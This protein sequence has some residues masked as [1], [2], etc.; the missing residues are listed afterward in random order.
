MMTNIKLTPH[1]LHKLLLVVPLFILS[2]LQVFAQTAPSC[3]NTLLT[4]NQTF[5]VPNGSVY[6]VPP[7]STFNGS[8]LVRAGGHVIVCVNG[9][10]TGSVT[11]DPGGT[12]WD[13]PS[14]SYTGSLFV[15]GNRYNSAS[16]CAQFNPCT[17]PSA[18]TVTTPNPICAGTQTGIDGS[19][20]A[21]ATYSWEKEN[22][23]NANNWVAIGGNTEDLAAATIG[24]LTTTTRFRRRTSACSPAQSSAWVTVTISVNAL[25]TIDLDANNSSLKSGNDYQFTFIE[26][27]GLNNNIGDAS[28]LTIADDNA[29]LA[30]ATIVLTNKQ[31]GDY[32]TW[33]TLGGIS[34]TADSSVANRITLN[35]S[36]SSSVANYQTFIRGIIFNNGSNTPNTTLRNV[37]FVV[38]DGSCSSTTATTSITVVAV[39][40]KPV[41]DL[42]KT[43]ATAPGT[44]S[45]KTYN[46]KTTGV[47]ITNTSSIT[48]AD[49]T[50]LK[51]A[52]I[53]LTNKFIGDSILVKGALP[54]G[55]TATF[56]AVSSGAITIN[57]TSTTTNTLAE[58]QTALDLIQFY[59][60]SNNPITTDRIINFTVND[61][62]DN[63]NIAVATIKVVSVNDKTVLDLD[64]LSD[65]VATG[66]DYKTTYEE[67]KS[68]VTIGNN[69]SNGVS[70]TDADNTTLTGA[71]IVLTNTKTADVFVVSN[72]TALTALGITAISTTAGSNT[73]IKFSGNVSLANYQSAIK[74]VTFSNTA[75][76][77]DLTTRL[78]KV[79][80][81]DGT[82][83][84][85]TA[86][87][88]IVFR[89]FNDC[90][91]LSNA[92]NY[93]TTFT[94][95]GAKVAVVNSTF[96]ITDLDL[97][98]AATTQAWTATVQLTNG[99]SLD[100]LF[101]PASANGFTVATPV[102]AYPNVTVSITGTGTAANLATLIKAITYKTGSD[103]PST[104][105]R[106]ISILVKDADVNCNAG[107]GNSTI[108]ITA[109]ND[110]PTLVLNSPT[111]N[112]STTYTENG[113]GVKI[114]GTITV[115]DPD[116]NS[117]AWTAAIK[118]TNAFKLDSLKIPANVGSLSFGTPTYVA[119]TPGSITLGISGIGTS[120]QLASMI[121]N[122][123]YKSGADSLNLVDRNITVEVFDVASCKD[124][125]ATT[126]KLTAANDC[127]TLVLNSPTANYS[128]TYTENGAG[129][130]IAGTIAVNDPDGNTQAWTAAIK[131]TNAF[132]LDSLKIPANVGSLSFG[133]PTYVAGTPG[134]ITLGISGTGTSAQLASMIGNITY[135]SGADSLNLVDR[136][137]TVEVFDVASCKVSAA[138]TVKLTAANDCPTLVLNSPTANY[139]TTYTENGAGVKI[140]GS[141]AVND[142]DGNS[143]AWTAAIKL[144]NAFKLDSLK[145]PANANGFII[146]SP[147]FV[148]GFPGSIS[149]SISGVGK[150]IDLASLIANIKY[151]S[152][153]DSLNPTDR[154]VNVDIFD[155]SLCKASAQTTIILTSINDPF[156]VKQDSVFTATNTAITN[157]SLTTI[158]QNNIDPENDL[159]IVTKVN[160]DPKNGT[161]T[162][163]LVNQTYTYNPNNLYYGRDTIYFEVCDR[164]TGG[165]CKQDTLYVIIKKVNNGLKLD[166]D[167]TRRGTGY[168]TTF[169][170][171][172]DIKGVSTGVSAV[173]VTSKNVGLINYDLELVNSASI[174]LNNKQKGDTLFVKNG[175]LPCGLTYTTQSSSSATTIT[176]SGAADTTCYK[177]ALES[178]QFDNRTYD[179]SNTDRY[180]NISV[181]N[182]N[183]SSN[184]TTDTIKVNVVNQEPVVF[185][186]EITIKED[187]VVTSSLTF[188]LNNDYDPDGDSITIQTIQN[189]PLNGKFSIDKTKKT[190][191]YIPDQD[192]VGQDS[193]VISICDTKNACVNQK[194]KITILPVNDAPYVDLET[195]TKIGK[196][197][198]DFKTTFSEKGNA[199]KISN[200][201]AVTDVD[202][203]TLL[204]ATIT[205]TN[206]KPL[207]TLLVA[208]TLPNT[209]KATVT[210]DGSTITVTISTKN[211]SPGTL[212]DY[213]KA[214]S[215]IQFKN[216]SLS[217]DTT[218]RVVSVVVNDST[219][220]SN[221]AHAYISIVSSNDAPDVVDDS[222]VT[223]ED[224]KITVSVKDIIKNDKDPEGDTLTVKETVIVTKHG[225][226]TV[227]KDSVSYNPN[228]DYNGY[229]T[230]V[231][232][233]CDK[234]N[235]CTDKNIYIRVI[236]INDNP[237]LD[238]DKDNSSGSLIA[239]FD[240]AYTENGTG[241]KISDTDILITDTDDKTGYTDDIT[242]AI[243]TLT[244]TKKGDVLVS[245][246]TLP[247]GVTATTTIVDNAT[248]I[249]I[250]GSS[251]KSNYQTIINNIQYS[252]TEDSLNTEDRKITVVI[253]D[254]DSLSNVATTT[255][256]LINTND[257]IITKTTPITTKEDSVICVSLT[258]ITE[259]D[260]DPEGD[261]ITVTEATISTSNGTVVIANGTLCYNPKKDFN[262]KDS[263]IISVCDPQGKC[264]NKK[265]I[266][267]VLPVNDAPYIDLEI[268]TKLGKDSADYATKYKEQTN[269]IGISNVS[270][271]SD[272]DNTS[273]KSATIVLTN[274]KALDSLKVGTLPTNLDKVITYT[275]STITV[276]ISTK[277]ATDGT[278]FDYQAAINA[279]QFFSTNKNLDSTTRIVKVFVKD[280]SLRSNIATASIK[281]E[282][283]NDDPIIKS[284]TLTVV[285]DI[286]ITK[287]FKTLLANDKDPENTTLTVTGIVKNGTKGNVTFTDSTY[288]Y[289]PN[290]NV[291]GKDTVVFTVCD[292]G[293]SLPRLCKND[294][295]FINIIPVNDDPIVKNEYVTI[296]KNNTGVTINYLTNDNDIETKIISSGITKSANHGKVSNINLTNGTFI[297]VPDK[298]FVGK[299]TVIFTVCDQGLPLPSICKE[300]TIFI[301]VQENNANCTIIDLDGN[302]SSKQLGYDFETTFVE[303]ST[304]INITDKDL[305]IYDID[306]NQTE[307]L[308]AKVVLTNTQAGDS[309]YYAG[310]VFPKLATVVAKVNNNWEITFT[311]L[312]DTSYYRQAIAQIKFVNNRDDISS[313]RREIKFTLNDGSA[314]FL[315]GNCNNSATTYINIV[316][317]YDPALILNEK[318]TL[319]EDEV[320]KNKYTSITKNDISK[321]GDLILV[322]IKTCKDFLCYLND[323]LIVKNGN[324]GKLNYS[325]D[326]VFTYSPNKN[327]N[328][329]DTVVVKVCDKTS[330]Y[331]DTLFIDVTPVNDSIIVFN[332]Y[333]TLNHGQTVSG[334]V[335][336]NDM[337]IDGTGVKL[338][339]VLIDHTNLGVNAL[340]TLTV[341]DNGQYTY[342]AN[343]N[344]SGTDIYV[345]TVCSQP[346]NYSC[347]YDTLFFKV[348]GEVIPTG[349]SPNGDG[350]NDT[351]IISYPEAYGTAK[352]EIYNRWGEVVFA[353]NDY[354]NAKG[355]YDISLASQWNGTSNK[356]VTI[357]N[358]LPDGTYFLSIKF[359]NN[360][361]ADKVIAI[362]LLR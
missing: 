224:T 302:N 125:A 34:I 353:N 177:N 312:T 349:F 227:T 346:G 213:Q 354:P 300:D 131:L 14:T 271:V 47:T 127:P 179:L 84:S 243:I 116:G 343:N 151:L 342:V 197:S 138:T 314:A 7:G 264:S 53:I 269:P 207:D 134:S 169:T 303:N 297:Y 119:G 155:N 235:V 272:I 98:S 358:E 18:G 15:A 89:A 289:N 129:V 232:S 259:N 336:T 306:E 61:G 239:D 181:S 5:I 50:T 331:N 216:T 361:S 206:K 25:P 62:T 75:D 223:K 326:S 290:L 146:S 301:T 175:T 217:P 255:I 247:N 201:V 225:T 95:N 139:S 323:S 120:A 328:G 279:V 102:Y 310:P 275:D 356:G 226:F 183:G 107:T 340:G 284:D 141:I 196:D 32:F 285:E 200:G 112:Y 199:I 159:L 157:K 190:F 317:V 305:Y 24:N 109:T 110:C 287:D 202:N 299:D 132:K 154:I 262:G 193:V 68:G 194:L 352:V 274:K 144:T 90:P 69:K 123:T 182:I 54:T 180:I 205:L 273:L 313:V 321:D 338:M 11:I 147:T 30:S 254:G 65:S 1:N 277:K 136:N 115:N 74:L 164:P 33:T 250:N 280:D 80:V 191:T 20:V 153:A 113:A 4:G 327:F 244:N 222:L 160:K 42:D 76:N 156:I 143:Q 252:N 121:G 51:S 228:K 357:G 335:I 242:T 189:H 278:V 168:Y 78:V 251:S 161:L 184:L 9:T 257:S 70:I 333:H 245:T 171:G 91:T 38:S 10:F 82:D 214:I 351:Y 210:S 253:S 322:S 315:N 52:K 66:F 345:Y 260:K 172:F 67:Q 58:Y 170:E 100:S 360:S 203:N 45:L 344:V 187:S 238:L 86:N 256:R 309:M 17:A 341:F 31:V 337:N 325:T 93:A 212:S 204:S 59:S 167:S 97:A 57:L 236:P 246:G 130:K 12:L 355:G 22:T 152:G 281:I 174:I 108:S 263:V 295:L 237:F 350:V 286:S 276:V 166:L 106:T 96:S 13:S 133:T 43:N 140:A 2:N 128:T 162:V 318:I 63:S 330:C 103:N 229:D 77:P 211:S 188:L 111:A 87:T 39:N 72:T 81:F 99:V 324:H 304:A 126:L 268:S 308:S 48:D 83:S 73:Y 35:I 209:L 118:L 6:C 150:S 94:E 55:I 311:G 320:Y 85:N 19:A 347:K 283:V 249:T 142:P 165:N 219:L 334:S 149:V 60:L 362:T 36:G 234:Q 221:I 307:L 114:A 198:A 3:T 26:K 267:T 88:T 293:F 46:E 178:I 71:T 56:G 29:N 148:S 359:S 173:D 316:P 27:N 258:K 122:I 348:G 64:A 339:N 218:V 41:L 233:V 104:T 163:D 49:N 23:L 240:T 124:S 44:S 332:E 294:T 101:A 28:D 79:T 176:I 92:S 282:T 241:I 248:I 37:T 16:S 21:S 231:V 117:Q 298:Y 135:K 40:D 261:A 220:S 270:L 215:T 329:K 266:I 158:Q 195:S 8:L 192:Y 265:V 145:I 186:K 296:K 185:D 137:I 208:S 288:T 230:V 105:A 292:N 291:N 319:K